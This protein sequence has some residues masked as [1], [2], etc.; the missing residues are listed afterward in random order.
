[1]SRRIGMAEPGAA[2]C[3]ASLVF[4][5]AVAILSN[6][7]NALGHESV[8]LGAA[9]GRRLAEPVVAR[10]DGPRWDCAAMDGYALRDGDLAAGLRRFA[11][12]GEIV[13]GD[14][15]L[16]AVTPGSTMR[17][18]TGAPLPD[19]AD[20]VVMIEYCTK[21]GGMVEIRGDPGSKPHVRR[22]GSDFVAGQTLLN[23]GRELTPVALVAAAAG[24]VSHVTVWRRPRVH[25]IATGDEL[26]PP[27]E[28]ANRADRIPDSLTAAIAL[29]SGQWGGCVVRET[30]I[31]DD[32][33]A[34]RDAFSKEDDVTVIIGGASR[35]DRDFGRSALVPVGL[36]L[37]FADVAIKPGKPSWYGK[38]GEAHVLGLPGNPTAALTVARLFL[39]PLLTGL[40]GGE[41][42]SALA[43]THLRAAREVE[44]QGEREAFLI[45]DIVDG[46]ALLLDR[47]EASAQNL[48]GQ[49]TILVRRPARAPR[50]AAGD[51]LAV[52]AI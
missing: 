32:P 5:D 45:G 27:G 50:C 47:Q 3:Q 41:P 39:A 4:D 49:A 10:I 40:G 23:K 31:G 52:L 2:M 11:S 37:L 13:A 42:R 16:T 22:R 18:M 6:A 14:V 36:R 28:A 43:W 35:G 20:R 1:M 8:A 25:I 34:I 7:A 48:L 19:G 33:R 51:A 15:A 12:L 29:L 44:A 38:V 9:A 24:D 46:A 21:I 30:R 26:V 17:V